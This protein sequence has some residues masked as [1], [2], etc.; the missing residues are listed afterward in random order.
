MTKECFTTLFFVLLATGTARATDVVSFQKEILPL[1]AHRC[2]MCHQ[3]DDP[4][5]KLALN[6]YQNLLQGGQSGPVVKPGAPDESLLVRYVSGEK[7]RMP[8]VGP[9]LTS[10]EAE[11]I[12]RWVAQGAKDDGAGE[13]RV[14]QET[15]WSLQ[16]LA[17]HKVPHADSTWI[18]TPIDAFVLAQLRQKGLTPSPEADKRTLIRR[19]SF[20]L[21]GLPPT[22]EELQA[23]LADQAPDAYERLVDRL[24]ASPRY[25]ERWGR[26]WLDVVHYGDSHGYDKDKPRLNAWP[27]RDYVI[28]SLNENKSYSRFVQEQ[29]AGDVLFP[30]EPDGMI[31]TGFIAAGPWDLVGHAELREGTTDK[32]IARV[33]DRDDMVTATISTFVS[34]TVHCAR[35][36]DHKFDPIKQEDYYSLQ[37]VFAGVDRADRPFD[38][39]PQKHRRRQILLQQKRSI[40]IELQP[41][42]DKVEQIASPEIAQIDN[43]L[44]DLG[45]Q[46]AA[47][48]TP[49]SESE[50][51]L[52][53]QFKA[54]VEQAAKR[55]KELV[56][57]L[58]DSTTHSAIEHLTAKMKEVDQLIEQLGKP[59][60]VYAE[61]SFFERNQN[62]RPA[63]QPR[64]IHLLMR[65]NVQAPGQL[66]GP[67][68]IS[69]VRTL[70][71]RFNL[72]NPNDEGSRRAA[73]AKWV[74]DPNN[75]L[76]WRSIVN[77]VWQNHFGTGIVD[78]PNDFGRMGSLSTHPELL[79]WLALWFRDE[80]RGSLKSL[81]RLIVT[82]A[83]YRQSS[84]YRIDEARI[85]SDNRFLWRMNRTRLDAESIH[86]SV[87]QISGKLDLKMGGPGVQQFYF[88]D[89]HSPVYDYARFDVDSPDSSR[90][91]V[92]R[93][94]VRSVA[95]P[96]MDRL[97]CPNASLLTP[98]RTTT[99]TAIQA[100]ALL[101]N[102]FMVRMSQHFAT[103]IKR[104][105]D[106]VPDQF[107]YAYRLAL[108]REPTADESQVFVA[109]ITKHGLENACRLI[110]NSN[111]F[112]FVD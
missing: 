58:V 24:L 96:F 75:M 49:K 92:Y 56:D 60:L 33:L 26:Y 79:D 29:I 36:H 43:R 64:P 54:D 45:G 47:L 93:F 65:G 61:S 41:L 66:V 50:A 70:P 53:K 8:K 17:H 35:C 84:G 73:L 19:L 112:L 23:F 14:G 89:D 38:I 46:L 16:P 5:G 108:G 95:D 80:A 83:A 67:G 3:G 31:A 81:D 6:S 11:L 102:P 37:A 32:E 48:T 105:G 72:D 15:W 86:D 85:D 62:F 94:L 99:L 51:L 21:H 22:P 52:K 42:L 27:Y 10:Q 2:Q 7:P 63:L 30:D 88:K 28:R 40:Q 13:T 59:Q 55:R 101:N 97:D 111:E 74:T 18:R 91:S 68:A 90:R 20:D 107:A 69:C 1:L 76:T 77:R 110:F 39:D 104:L 109:Y 9:P 78:T 82:S 44:Q 57:A 4:Q 100:L 87:L 34:L 98:K 106:N 71:A 12:R 103:R 25:G